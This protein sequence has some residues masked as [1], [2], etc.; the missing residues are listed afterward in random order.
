M[1]PTHSRL[2][3]TRIHFLKKL[4]GK[5]NEKAVQKAVSI[6]QLWEAGLL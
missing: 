4:L 1:T 6:L 5:N 3:P 2:I